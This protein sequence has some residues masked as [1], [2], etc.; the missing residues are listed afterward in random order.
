MVKTLP[1]FLEKKAKVLEVLMSSWHG[2]IGI[3]PP[4]ICVDTDMQRVF[5][6]AKDEDKIISFGFEFNMV[7]ADENPNRDN[8]IRDIR[9]RD[10]HITYTT[11]SG[12]LSILSYLQRDETY[13]A[14]WQQS[15]IDDEEEENIDGN[16]MRLFEYMRNCETGYLRYDDAPKEVN[17]PVHPQYHIDVNYMPAVSYK[18][19]L[20]KK[21]SI[22][23]MIQMIDPT[24]MCAYLQ[25]EHHM[26]DVD[27]LG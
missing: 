4:Y 9:Y 13:E 27:N 1:E 12:V 10:G 7:L 24:K 19:G 18:L 6:V 15:L 25:V 22:D 5:V 20:G 26:Y 17:L 2:N 16:T 3:R 8:Y 23:D 11:I 14:N 21:L